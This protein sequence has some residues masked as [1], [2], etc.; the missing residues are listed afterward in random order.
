MK[1]LPVVLALVLLITSCG[2][3]SSSSTTV[4]IAISPTQVTLTPSQTAQ[5]VA[6]VTNSSN[7]SVTWQVNG[8]EGGNTSVGVISTAGAYT[9]PASVTVATSVTIT[10][11]SQADITQTATA[12][13][14]LNPTNTAP[15][16]PVLVSPASAVLTSGALQTFTATISGAAA[17]VTWSVSC[18]AQSPADCGS[19]TQTGIYT[20]PFFPPPSGSATIT[21]T[22]TDGV[23][24]PGNAPVTIRISNQSLFGQYAFA[25]SGGN[26]SAASASAGSVTFDGQGNVTGGVED[27]AGNAGSPLSVTGGSYHIGTDGR[28]SVTLQTSS[29]TSTWQIAMVNHSHVYITTFDTNNNVNGGTMDVQTPSQFNAS[30]IQGN[31]SFAFAGAS[32]ANPSGA[33]R[34]AGAFTA[35][36][37]GGISQGLFDVNDTGTA[38][39]S[40]ALSGSFSAPSSQ[41]RGTMTLTSSAGTQTFVYYLADGTRLKLMETD[42]SAKGTAELLKQSAGPFTAAGLRGSFVTALRGADGHGPVSTG[43]IVTLDGSTSVKAVVDTN[44]NGNNVI[45]Q[46]VSGSYAVT[47]ATTGRTTLSWT[48]TDG[49]HQ[50]VLYPSANGDMNL[51]EVDSV[52]ASGP[53]LPQLFV[54]FSNAGFSG[55]FATEASGIDFSG[56]A[57]PV[58]FSGQWIFNG[59]SAISGVLD[60]NNNGTLAAGSAAK[61]SYGFDSTGRATLNVTSGAPGFATAQLGLYAA[62]G[63][64][65]LYIDTDS[66]RVLTGVLRKQY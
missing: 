58:A 17:T 9:A 54:G 16:A 49:T 61:G 4:T 5:F 56:S 29:G 64:R 57:G 7:T 44:N 62:D 27:V 35:D 60:I 21:A 10:A 23:S 40:L 18:P 19:I 33:L 50:F 25:L 36:G 20:A 15:A 65:A 2:G 32:S 24:L 6:T 3:G 30:A 48:A 14:V 34:T 45:G 53:A 59:G 43:G 28:G 63:N 47:D 42:A 26:G 66:N 52:S 41:G 12:T 8:I 13:V 31:Y 22:A 55:N 38:Q 11:I 37:A 51:L 46:S 1:F 39:T